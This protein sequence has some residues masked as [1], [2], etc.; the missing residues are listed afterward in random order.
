M[1]TRVET[2]IEQVR[3][4][5]TEER[6]QLFEAVFDRAVDGD[7]LSPEWQAE[8]RSRIE[9]WERGELEVVDSAEL[10]ARLRASL[11]AS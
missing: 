7:V 9:A 3:A 6:M 11:Q 8:I 10:H 4:L 1:N 2:L 5:S